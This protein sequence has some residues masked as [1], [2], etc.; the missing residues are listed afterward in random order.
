[1]ANR[2]T[3]HRRIGKFRCTALEKTVKEKFANMLSILSTGTL[4]L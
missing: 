4:L 2:H 3:K 1:M